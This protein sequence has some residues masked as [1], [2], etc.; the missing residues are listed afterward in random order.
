[1]SDKIKQEVIET[2]SNLTKIPKEDID[3]TLS[4]RDTGLD[5]FALV[6]VVFAIENKYD[7]TFPQESLLEITTV[8]E[9]VAF[10]EKL[11]KEKK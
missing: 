4:F 2:V 1:M 8:D 3:P 5:S 10:I 9:F 11:L 7:I 6:E